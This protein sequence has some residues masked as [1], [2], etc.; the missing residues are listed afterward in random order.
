MFEICP[1][2][3]DEKQRI[4]SRPELFRQPSYSES[5]TGNE[6]KQVFV[7]ARHS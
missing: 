7:A 4:F 3:H 1:C 6:T 2:V 5:K